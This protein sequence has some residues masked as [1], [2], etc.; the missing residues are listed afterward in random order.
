MCGKGGWMGEKVS[1]ALGKVAG[2]YLRGGA[3]SLH[4]GAPGWVWVWVWREG[5][6]SGSLLYVH[7]TCLAFWRDGMIPPCN[8]LSMLAESLLLYVYSIASLRE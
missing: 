3:E 1:Y 7:L 8:R 6:E 4:G 5:E 2:G